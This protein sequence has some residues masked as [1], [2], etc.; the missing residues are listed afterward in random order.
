VAFNAYSAS[1]HLSTDRNS[2]VL[3]DVFYA[4]ITYDG[5]S[6]ETPDFSALEKDF[7]IVSNSTSQSM[8]SI[9][10]RVS[11]S[12]QWSLGLIPLHTGKI[13][14]GPIKLDNLVSNRLEIEVKDLS[15]EVLAPDSKTNS[16]APYFKIEQKVDTKSPYLR[17]QVTFFVTIYASFNL[18]NPSLSL[19][20]DIQQ[21]WTL[22]PLLDKPIVRKET[23]NGKQM[24]VTQYAFAG[25]PQKSGTIPAPQFVF[26]GFYSK[27]TPFE[28]SDFDE[29]LS[30]FGISFHNV[31]GQQVP[32]RMQTK[33]FTFDVKPIP[34]NFKGNYW[35]PLSDFTVTADWNNK[36]EVRVGDAVT[37]TLKFT[38]TGTEKNLFPTISLPE[39]TNLKQYPEKPVFKETVHQGQL[40]TEAQINTVYIPTK[41]GELTIPELRLNW[42]DVDKNIAKTL[43][44]PAE[45]LSIL[46]SANSPTSF[47]NEEEKPEALVQSPLTE[48]IQKQENISKSTLWEHINKLYIGCFFSF[49]LLLALLVFIF[50]H[51]K[52]TRQ[53]FNNV[54]SS[55]KHRDYKAVREALIVWANQKFA[56]KV[57][58][59]LQDIKQTVQNV[60]FAEQLDEL[61][62]VLYSDREEIFDI[63]KFIEIF[64]KVD[65]IKRSAKKEETILPELYD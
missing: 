42:F 3:G 26:N 24:L 61:N 57:F 12:I 20:N 10:G 9:N 8:Q 30:F 25:F 56:P 34:E 17:Q 33:P 32:V 4:T 41:S 19:A 29:D 47:Q 48:S 64:K 62:K 31:L 1:L 23:I 58:R 44:L 5:Q 46:P 13:F 36:K 65:R 39:A 2:V 15:N 14:L 54:I 59:N 63:A 7:Q 53:S 21:D 43:V 28:F 50:L 16:N 27:G 18:K 35:L 40:V 45:S 22:T 55:L 60:S 51:H 38:A 11:R 37:R 6:N 49:L 52:K